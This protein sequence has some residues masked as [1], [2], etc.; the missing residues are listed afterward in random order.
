MGGRIGAQNLKS[1]EPPSELRPSSSASAPSAARRIGGWSLPALSGLP[2][3]L[4]S[5]FAAFQNPPLPYHGRKRAVFALLFAAFLLLSGGNARAQGQPDLVVLGP[6]VSETSVETGETFAF[7][8]TVTNDGDAQSQSAATT[9]RYLRSTDATITK[10]DTEEG[11]D[12]VRALLLNQGYAAT[13]RLTAPATAGTYYYGAVRGRG[14]RG[15]RH[16]E[17]LLGRGIGRG[18]GTGTR[19]GAENVRAGISPEP[20]GGGRER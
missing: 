13:I 3:V 17:Q 10:S 20:D 12:E 1:Q 2:V 6:N 18:V 4:R 14:G 9:V 15:V 16:G 19:P 8:A 11:T 5:V 7:I